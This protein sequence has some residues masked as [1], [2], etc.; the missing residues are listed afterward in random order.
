MRSGNE[1][2]VCEDPE[3]NVQISCPFLIS[4][5]A[6]CVA[7]GH[8]RM[9]RT[10]EAAGVSGPIQ[11]GHENS[12]RFLLWPNLIC[13]V[14]ASEGDEALSVATFAPEASTDCVFAGVSDFW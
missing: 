4:S 9:K 5:F 1:F 6:S 14:V 2:S 11:C 12:S 3:V 8:G 13:Q 10:Q 7:P